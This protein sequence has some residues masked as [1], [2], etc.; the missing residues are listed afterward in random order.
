MTTPM[1]RLITAAPRP[2]GNHEARAEGAA[3]CDGVGDHAVWGIAA[4]VRRGSTRL[5]AVTQHPLAISTYHTPW[6]PGMR[7]RG[8]AGA[9]VSAMTSATPSV[10]PRL[11][12]AWLTAEPA[13]KLS[14]GRPWTDTD[15]S[16]GRT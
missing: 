7:S 15:D 2:R 10:A 14:A 6:K 9:A 3:S 1:R 8:L 16:W 5:S 12:T 11:R 4:G 13:P